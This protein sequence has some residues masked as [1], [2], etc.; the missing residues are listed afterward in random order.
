MSLLSCR[1]FLSGGFACI[2]LRGSRRGIGGGWS[3]FKLGI[4]AIKILVSLGR[5]HICSSC[6]GLVS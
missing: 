5:V 2:R 1:G 3:A 6:S 4:L